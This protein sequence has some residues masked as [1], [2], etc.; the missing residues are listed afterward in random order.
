MTSNSESILLKGGSVLVTGAT[1]D[2]GRAIVNECV[3]AG[4]AVFA[5][6]RNEAK[7]AALV[8]QYESRVIPL[9]YDVTDE[10]AVKD[11]FRQIQKQQNQSDIGPLTGLVNNAGIMEEAAFTVSGM[12]ALKSQLNVNF[13]A[14][15]QH[16]QL[17]SRLMARHRHGSIVNIVSQ[18][19]EMGA[20][21]MSAYGASKAAL[22]GATKSLAKELAAVGIRVNAVSPGFIDTG[23][24]AHYEEDARAE[25]EAR[26]TMKRA[27][28]AGDV[29]R[30][31]VFLLSRQSAYTTGHTLP[32][33]GLF[34]P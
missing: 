21:G 25:V 29:A 1:G 33:D 27:G 5:A 34:Y 20:T 15:Y 31:V 28:R 4:A 22:S 10:K 2:I 19:G 26:I 23:L 24:T 13:L 32:V 17:A 18:I 11:A 14:P 8:N 30:A 9:N 16:M 7:L 3:Q 12:D 6:G